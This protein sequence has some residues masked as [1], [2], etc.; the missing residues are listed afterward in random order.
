[1]DVPKIGTQERDGGSL[2]RPLV[3]VV[4]SLGYALNATLWGIIAEV[5]LPRQKQICPKFG[6]NGVEETRHFLG[7]WRP[8]AG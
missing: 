4:V 1:M 2:Q 5:P 3:H 6:Q 8:T 7:V